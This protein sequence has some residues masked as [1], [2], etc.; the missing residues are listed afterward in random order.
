METSV[1]D[2]D[3]PLL[4]VSKTTLAL[5][6]R[7]GITLASLNLAA[8]PFRNLTQFGSVWHVDF[9]VSSAEV[10]V[11]NHNAT[12]LFADIVNVDLNNTAVF[13]HNDTVV[14]LHY[15]MSSWPLLNLFT[16]Q[17]RFRP[18]PLVDTVPCLVV[19]TTTGTVGDDAAVVVG[20]SFLLRSAVVDATTSNC[21]YTIPGQL[22]TTTQTAC[23]TAT[24]RPAGGVGWGSG[25]GIDF[26][27]VMTDGNVAAR[28]C[29]QSP[30]GFRRFTDGQFPPFGLRPDWR[31]DS[32]LAS[33]TAPSSLLEGGCFPYPLLT[34]LLS[35]PIRHVALAI[36]AIRREGCV[37]RWEGDDPGRL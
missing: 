10:T 5:V 30:N 11:Y 23:Q 37:H 6:A 21:I 9:N 1:V 20:K 25:C 36:A 17:Y 8:L 35:I 27:V 4:I 33:T 19:A 18:V 12:A 22:L 32:S 7:N 14:R 26:P 31:Y 16:S 24:A 15:F 34:Q 3:A 29:T 28:R 13:G 2:P